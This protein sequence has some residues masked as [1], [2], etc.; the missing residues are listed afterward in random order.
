[1]ERSNEQI[2][3]SYEAYKCVRCGQGAVHYVQLYLDGS[4]YE[5]SS[6][7]YITDSRPK[8]KEVNFKALMTERWAY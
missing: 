7:G 1:M 8:A 6:C 2:G 4:V 5:C 3:T